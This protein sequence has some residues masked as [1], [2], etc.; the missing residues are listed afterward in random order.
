MVSCELYSSFAALP[1]L[2]NQSDALPIHPNFSV[3][4]FALVIELIMEVFIRP[5]EW[6]ALIK[7]DKAFFPST[8][9]YLST[10]HLIAETVSLIFFIPEF[11]CVFSEKPCGGIRNGLSLG[12]L[13]ISALFGPSKLDSFYGNAYLC[14]LRLRIFGLVRHWTKMWL[15][16]TFV[17]EKGSN[18]EW[19]IKRGKGLLI[20]QGKHIRPRDEAAHAIGESGLHDSLAFSTRTAERIKDAHEAGTHTTTD[21]YHLTNASKIGTALFMTNARRALMWM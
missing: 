8:C 16:C 20:P 7:S 17:L 3:V 6:R 9:R 12:E 2:A 18:G 1:F 4:W 10:F 14:M 13:V 11:M 15:N 21:D 19:Q 5:S